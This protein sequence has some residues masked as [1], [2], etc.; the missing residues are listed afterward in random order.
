MGH[1]QIFEFVAF[2]SQQ[3]LDVDRYVGESKT[4]LHLAVE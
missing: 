1:D 2:F 3:T 4:F